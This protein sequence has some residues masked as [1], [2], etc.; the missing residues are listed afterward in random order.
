RE[1]WD[2]RTRAFK[3]STILNAWASAGIKPFNP[4]VFTDDDYAP[5]QPS[6]TETYLP[7]SYPK[8]LPR[9]PDAS[10]DDALFDPEALRELEEGREDNERRTSNVE[11]ERGSGSESE[12]DQS[13]VP[14]DTDDSS[15][16]S[17]ERSPS[18]TPVQPLTPTPSATPVPLL[19]PASRRTRSWTALLPSS[20]LASLSSSS[21]PSLSLSF[22]EELEILRHENAYLKDQLQAKT[23]SRVLLEN[24]LL[25]QKYANALDEVTLLK[26]QRDAAQVHAVFAGQQYSVYKHRY[27][28]KNKKK[29]N[30]RRVS[31][32]ARILTSE[33]GRME[34]EEDAIR[35]ADKKKADE[36]KQKQKSVNL[37][38]DI[39][40]RAKQE[41]LSSVFSGNI[42]TMSKSK[43]VD[44]AFALKVPYDDTTAEVLCI[45]LKAHFDAN[46][47]LKKHPRYIGLFERTRKRKDPP[48][49]N[50]TQ[51]TRYPSPPG[52][53]SDLTPRLPLQPSPY[54][55][56]QHI[57]HDHE[58]MPGPSTSAQTYPYPQT[59]QS[60]YSSYSTSVPPVL[61]PRPRFNPFSYPG[62]YAN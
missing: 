51:S 53:M 47:E 31:T 61:Q 48:K 36:E 8:R 57:A 14:S 42:N 29:D 23:P 1:Y 11:Q 44:I 41:R 28:E 32:S 20:S 6:S 17:S 60:T 62:S 56:S 21:L 43:L 9:A 46:E 24:T 27:N 45:R 4:G 19:M 34:I 55:F 37:H 54:R 13:F 58:H 25:R 15:D 12:S 50:D 52:T 10:S 16:D 7:D 3:D 26:A 38:A 33:Q 30:S 18:P 49:E 22:S 59:P 40:R 39:V 2:C 5:S 35:R